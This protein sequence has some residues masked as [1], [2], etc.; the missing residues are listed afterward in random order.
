MERRLRNLTKIELPFI[1]YALVLDGDFRQVFP[2][3]KRGTQAYVVGACLTN[4]K[5]CKD[6]KEIHLKEYMS[7]RLNPEFLE[8]LLQIGDEVEPYVADDMVKHPDDIVL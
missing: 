4:A 7:S 3:A 6:V 8:F 1:F 5:L 2:M